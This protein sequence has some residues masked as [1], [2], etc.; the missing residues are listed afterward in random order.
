MNNTINTNIP[1]EGQLNILDILDDFE[2]KKEQRKCCKDC[3][4]FNSEIEQPPAGWGKIG[5][6][7]NHNHKVSTNSYCQDLEEEQ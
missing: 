4:R 5:W 1:L 3:I 7:N 6:C 2:P